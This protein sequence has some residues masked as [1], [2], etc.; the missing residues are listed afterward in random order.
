MVLYI[1]VCMLRMKGNLDP[2]LIEGLDLILAL[3][4]SF[5]F[6]L[7]FLFE[8]VWWVDW[9]GVGVLFVFRLCKGCSRGE[10]MRC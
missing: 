3:P 2:V 5:L 8:Y 4:F 6:F 1:Y 9:G 7:I 10:E